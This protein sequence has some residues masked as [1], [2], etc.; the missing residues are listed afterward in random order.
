MREETD[1]L[2]QSNVKHTSMERLLST[3]LASDIVG[4]SKMMA[5]DEEQ[6]LDLLRQR[7]QVIDSLSVDRFVQSQAYRE[8]NR[9]QELRETLESIAVRPFKA[10]TTN[11]STAIV[12]A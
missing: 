5:V 9:S 2:G 12:A 1:Y 3:I 8:E 7:R 4:F 6:T 10:R 11:F